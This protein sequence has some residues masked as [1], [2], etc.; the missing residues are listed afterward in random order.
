MI[1]ERALELATINDSLMIKQRL[2]K[3]KA[4]FIFMSP[5]NEFNYLHFFLSLD[6]TDTIV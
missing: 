6:Y 1:A 4:L 3:S 5:L 2:R